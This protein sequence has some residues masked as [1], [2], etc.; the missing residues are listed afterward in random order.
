MGEAQ[1]PTA[2]VMSDDDRTPDE[3]PELFLAAEE[4]IEAGLLPLA[5]SL[6]CS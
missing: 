6:A 2:E 4:V 5:S 1:W 3:D